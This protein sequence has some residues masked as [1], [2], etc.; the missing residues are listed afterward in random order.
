M[1]VAEIEARLRIHDLFSRYMKSVDNCDEAELFACFT[2]D[3]VLETPVLG[4]R[5]AGRDGQRRFLQTSQKTH[6]GSQLRH[7]FTNL[8]VELDGASAIARAYLVV[9]KTRDGKTAILHTGHYV[10]R[11]VRVG[12]NWFFE[13]RR[14]FIDG[15]A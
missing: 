10:C 2:E 7:L 1:Q 11:L 8:E 9:N 6:E 3:G 5:F 12:D 14:V 13:H 15:K 4:G